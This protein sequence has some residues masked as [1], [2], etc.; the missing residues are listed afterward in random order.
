[1]KQANKYVKQP[2][3]Y[4]PIF[5]W[6]F[7]FEINA[8]PNSST[9]SLFITSSQYK[10]YSTRNL[11]STLL[12]VIIIKLSRNKL[13]KITISCIGFYDHLHPPQEGHP[14]VSQECWQ[15]GHPHGGGGWGPQ[16]SSGITGALN[17]GSHGG[18]QPHGGGGGPHGGGGPPWC[19]G[20][21]P[22]W[23]GGGGGGPP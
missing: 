16:G 6:F 20:G 11:K 17:P 5:S 3:P 18:G 21:G 8:G 14:G 23:C 7:K 9:A 10:P 1:M 13:T 19:G 2:A 22:P 12:S 15:G 4:K